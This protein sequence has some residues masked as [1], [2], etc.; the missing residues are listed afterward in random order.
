MQLTR[1]FTGDDGESHFE[2]YDI[3]L[4]D[5]G[6]IG[7]LSD[8]IPASGMILRETGADYDY[9]WHNAPRRQFIIMLSGSGVEIETGDGSRREF[10]PG[11][12]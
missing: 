1:L 12:I 7:T 10:G 5:G 6:P 4:S 11:D 9:D 3:P 2:D 8:L